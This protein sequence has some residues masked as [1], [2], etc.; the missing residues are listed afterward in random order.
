MARK[1]F[2]ELRSIREL[3]NRKKPTDGKNW[4]KNLLG[5]R[6]DEAREDSRRDDDQNNR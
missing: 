1:R 6:L 2:S 3:R 5:V 4:P